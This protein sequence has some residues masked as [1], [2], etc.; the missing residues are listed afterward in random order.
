MSFPNNG[1][2]DVEPTKKLK[3]DGLN[4]SFDPSGPLDIL[5]ELR[6]VW[7]TGLEYNSQLAHPHYFNLQFPTEAETKSKKMGF[8]ERRQEPYIDTDLGTFHDYVEKIKDLK[9]QYS[10]GFTIAGRAQVPISA[11][12]LEHLKNKLG[13][14]NATEWTKKRCYTY[15]IS[16]NNAEVTAFT[17]KNSKMVPMKP[18]P[19]TVWVYRA[20]HKLEPWF[21]DGSRYVYCSKNK[22]RSGFLE[23]C[24]IR[25]EH[26]ELRINSA[27]HIILKDYNLLTH[28]NGSQCPF[29][30][31]NDLGR[32]VEPDKFKAMFSPDRTR[33]VEGQIQGSNEFN[34]VLTGFEGMLGVAMAAKSQP[35]SNFDVIAR[36]W[37]GYVDPNIIDKTPF[38]MEISEAVI[39][40]MA[41]CS[42]TLGSE[43]SALLH[44]TTDTES[45]LCKAQTLLN[46]SISRELLR[47]KDHKKCKFIPEISVRIVNKYSTYKTNQDCPLPIGSH[48]NGLYR[49]YFPKFAWKKLIMKAG[50]KLYKPQLRYRQNIAE[51]FESERSKLE[52][53]KKTAQDG[54]LTYSKEYKGTLTQVTSDKVG[55]V[56]KKRPMSQNQVMSNQSASEWLHRSAWSFGGLDISDRKIIYDLRSELDEGVDDDG[57]KDRHKENTIGDGYSVQN[58]L[59]LVLGTYEANTMMLRS[60]TFIKRYVANA[61]VVESMDENAKVPIKMSVRTRLLHGLREADHFNLRG[62]ST[63]FGKALHYQFKC[64]SPVWPECNRSQIFWCFHRRS[65]M[66]LE[67]MLDYFMEKLVYN[68]KIDIK[69]DNGFTNTTKH[70]SQEIEEEET[71]LGHVPYDFEINEDMDGIEEGFA[72]NVEEV[73]VEG[74]MTKFVIDLGEV[75]AGDHLPD[76]EM[77]EETV[78]GNG[79]EGSEIEEELFIDMYTELSDVEQEKGYGNGMEVS[80]IGEEVD[81]GVNDDDLY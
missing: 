68:W 58:T 59:N 73:D 67:M 52:A 33:S 15:R 28:Q 29:P 61:K 14:I 2:V 60:E 80:G 18:I 16:R 40:Q 64:E 46:D 25:L 41:K 63:W 34:T 69:S 9:I 37:D 79:Q 53:L 4:P 26:L 35:R 5:D 17:S 49:L 65:P 62:S 3:T 42:E 12:D 31:W 47:L 78:G 22:P 81:S 11:P 1:N 48:P 43:M 70:A 72:T 77:D 10:N 54:K 6:K 27:H 56:P 19:V 55:S 66:R 74:H 36:F 39:E 44:E 57:S 20:V 50:G 75:D 76:I 51:L 45:K 32:L 38:V 24:Y 7:A 71:G 30:A 8:L 23:G 21:D 13:S